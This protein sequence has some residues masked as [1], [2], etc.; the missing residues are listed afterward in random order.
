MFHVIETG[1]GSEEFPAARLLH[2]THAP[3]LTSQDI[4]RTIGFKHQPDEVSGA[5]TA[6]TLTPIWWARVTHVFFTNPSP[7][8]TKGAGL[9]LFRLK[10]GVLHGE[11]H[12]I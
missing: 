3:I 11:R 12:D 10:G 6:Q 4:Y 9:F 7:V 8:H 5:D 1:S 2:S